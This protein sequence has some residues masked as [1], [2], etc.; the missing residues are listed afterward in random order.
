MLPL[1]VNFTDT[2]TGDFDSWYWTFG[3]GEISA[4]QHPT[5]IYTVSD[6]YTVTLTV[7]GPTGID[8]EIKPGYITVFPRIFVFL[9]LTMK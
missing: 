4:A 6:T 8:S 5:H 9:P 1:T 2:S 3:D 7:D